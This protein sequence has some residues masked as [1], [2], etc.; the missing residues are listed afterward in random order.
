MTD[1][2]LKRMS[3]GALLEMLIEQMEENERLKKQLCQ[4]QE[5]LQERR[6]K[7]ETAGSL[8]EAALLLNGVFQAADQAARQYLDNVKIMAAEKDERA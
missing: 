7:L 1:R 3:R 8:A 6:I 2:E 5:E 4:A